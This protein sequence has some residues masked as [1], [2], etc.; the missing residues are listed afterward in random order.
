MLIPMIMT[1]TNVELGREK[2]I[3][4]ALIE[5]ILP[6]MQ[7]YLSGSLSYEKAIKQMS[8]LFINKINSSNN[9]DEAGKIMEMI[10]N[11]GARA[12]YP[13]NLLLRD[14]NRTMLSSEVYT[15]LAKGILAGAE[16]CVSRNALLNKRA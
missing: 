4:E 9:R 6:K 13:V 12:A 8:N 16:L 15:S 2:V 10:V 1:T 3:K 7:E 14:D 5:A 11:N